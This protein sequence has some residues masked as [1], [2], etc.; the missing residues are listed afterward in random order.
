MA[1]LTVSSCRLV[2]GNDEHQ[3]TAPAG[4]AITAGQ[5]IR[6]DPTTGKFVLGNATAAGE[7]GDGFI[8]AK[9]AAIGESLTGFKGPAVLDLGEALAALSFADPVYLSDT[10]GKLADAAGTVSTVVGKVVPGWAGRGTADKL[11][12]LSL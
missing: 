9:D 10:D 11:L 6:L 12:R 5:Y 1:D 4:E 8:A 2:R 3:H 7:V